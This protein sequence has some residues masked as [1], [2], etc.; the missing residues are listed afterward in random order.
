MKEQEFF[1]FIEEQRGRIPEPD[2][3]ERF[4]NMR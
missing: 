1:R 3:T 4:F 2:E